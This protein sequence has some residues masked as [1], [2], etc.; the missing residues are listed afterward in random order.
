MLEEN[1]WIPCFGVY[2]SIFSNGF[3]ICIGVFAAISGY[4]LYKSYIVKDKYFTLVSRILTF[5]ITYLT[6]LFCVAIPYLILYEKFNV[7]YMF[8]NIL[9]LLHNDEMLY[10]SFSWYVKVY[11]ELLLILPIIKLLNPKIKILHTDIFV[12]IVIPLFISFNLPDAETY[13]VDW[14]TNILSSIRLLLIWYPVFHVGLIFAKYSILEQYSRHIGQCYFSNNFLN[15]SIAI[16]IM[17]LA[18]YYRHLMLFGYLTDVICVSIFIVMFDFCCKNGK[19]KYL[20]KIL[21]FIGIYSFQ[22]WLLSGMFF[23][24]TTE[25][26]WILVLPRYSILILIWKIVLLTPIAMLMKK[27]SNRICGLIMVEK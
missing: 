22:Y 10:L 7:R 18:V 13:F 26:Q 19:A 5:L 4:G 9:A 1:K 27:I 3:K 14:K 2:D 17:F 20:P 25:F 15:I 8:L 24:N 16:L 11:L 23:L 6:M 12:F 21:S